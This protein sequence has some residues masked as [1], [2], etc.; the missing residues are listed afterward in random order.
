MLDAYSLRKI[1]QNTVIIRVVIN[2]D[3]VDSRYLELAYLE[4]PL[5]S[6]W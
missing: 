4:Q 3:T 2:V 5:I 6:K 1:G